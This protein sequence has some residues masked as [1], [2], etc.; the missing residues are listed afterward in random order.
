MAMAIDSTEL[1]PQTV[2]ADG[3]GEATSDVKPDDVNRKRLVSRIT[4][5]IQADKKYHE[6]A[7]EQMREDMQFARRGADA[8]WLAD[9][10]YVANITGRHT[11]QKT[12]ALYAK[13]PQVV[14]RSRDRLDFQLWDGSPT[15]LQMAIQVIQMSTQAA[16]AMPGQPLPPEQE[17]QLAEAQALVADFQQGYNREQM[18]KKFGKTLEILFSQSMQTQ[19]PLDF[20]MG[21]KRVVRRAATTGV[22]YCEVNFQRETGPS[23]IT[24]SGLTDARTRLDHLRRLYETATDEDDTKSDME[25]E[26]AELELSITSLMSEPEIVLREGLVL[27]FPDSTKVIPDKLCKSLVGF[28]GA[29]HITIEYPYTVD[30]VK[31]TFNVDLGNKYTPYRTEDAFEDDE[32]SD[33][34][35]SEEDE[36]T[37]DRKGHGMVCVWKHYDKVSGLVYYLVDGYDDF[38]REP[39][40][41]DVFVSDFWPVY[42]LTFNDVESEKHL[43]PP[44]DVALMR[45]QQK[46]LNRS[47]QGMR[48]H[49]YA[50]MPRWLYRKGALDEQND[51]PLLQSAKPFQAIGLNIGDEK[52]ADV[53]QA[54]PVF[55]VDMNLYDTSQFFNDA[56]LVVGASASRLGGTSK[57]TATEAAIAE[58][59]AT[60]DDASGIDDLDAFLTMIARAAGQVLV[61]EMSPEQVAK[62]AGPGAV[63]PGLTEGFEVSREDLMDELWLEVEAGS[64]G[65]PNQAVE[66]NNWK[67][68]APLA[69]QIPGVSPMW[70]ARETIRRMDDRA[71]LNE[72]IA[73]GIPAM[74]AMNRNAQPMGEDPQND[75]NAQGPE[76]GDTTST[77]SGPSGTDAAFGSNQ[78]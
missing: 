56:T 62:M 10:K 68:L 22:G 23:A 78:M 7:F 33:L 31:E 21:M 12:N 65:K 6:D 24:S 46:E 36:Q 44:S 61:R 64:T 55:G 32:T 54:A 9:E 66:A 69:M 39:S 74:V 3:S 52:L 71:D 47:R 48:D 40:A 34:E 11:R 30:E 67:I 15:S 73:E 37:T 1:D 27:D 19:K 51:I 20:K 70:L 50:A 42:A 60:E 38:L 76:G 25:A 26:I 58:G 43:F 63:W 28:V 14:A 8:A 45:D 35:G 77:P 17:A 41:P 75:P 72:A 2:G 29:R 5:T 49:R 57:S 4:R 59:S 16:A 53:L 13:N 18:T